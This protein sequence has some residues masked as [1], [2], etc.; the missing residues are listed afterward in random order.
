MDVQALRH[1][2]DTAGD[3]IQMKFFYQPATD[4]SEAT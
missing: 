3:F 2:L 1:S 4:E